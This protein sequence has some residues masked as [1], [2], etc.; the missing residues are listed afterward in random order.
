MIYSLTY[1]TRQLYVR[2]YIADWYSHIGDLIYA[3]SRGKVETYWQERIIVSYCIQY[4][5]DYYSE[6]IA[7]VIIVI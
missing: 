6:F 2:M 4:C 1:D 7:Q 3:K 5:Y